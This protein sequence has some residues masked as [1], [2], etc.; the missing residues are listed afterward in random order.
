[1]TIVL[2]DENIAP[3]VEA[4]VIEKTNLTDVVVRIRLHCKQPFDYLSGQFIHIQADNDASLIRSY[5]LASQ[6]VADSFL[7]IHVS[8]VPQGKMSNWLHDGLAIGQEISISGPF[9]DCY[10]S[11]GDQQNGLLLL[12]TGTGL[13][14]LWGV[15]HDALEK[16]H[17][18]PIHLFH[19]GCSLSDLYLVDELRDLAAKHDNF[20]YSPCL[21]GAGAE[22][23]CD[24]A[25]L[26]RVQDQ[27]LK[28]YPD[29]KGWQVYLCGNP[30]MVEEA[31]RKV[32]MAG[33]E[34]GDIHADP[35]VAVP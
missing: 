28:L 35:F 2:P 14:P 3:H 8:R 22:T 30:A 27:A 23:D 16:R 26:G 12:A 24:Y 34:L 1:M 18:G 4:K 9:G 11:A 10:Y 17:A 31:K 13:A 19:G 33:A 15:L 6:P 20:N 21:D 5:S 25:L 29:L 7:E 32:F